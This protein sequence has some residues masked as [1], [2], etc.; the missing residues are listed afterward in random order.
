MPTAPAI[1]AMPA[2]ATSTSGSP[3]LEPTPMAPM[4]PR[5]GTIGNPP[6]RL[7]YLPVVAIASF[8]ATSAC[9]FARRCAPRDSGY[10][11]AYGGIDA[12]E[13]TPVN[14]HERREI[15]TIIDCRDTLRDD[16]CRG[17]R[18]GGFD[19]HQGAVIGE[20]QMLDSSDPCFVPHFTHRN[21]AG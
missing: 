21:S 11:L 20:A 1:A 7:M 16:R 6:L 5:S 13:F 19:D 8:I 3:V 10:R 15:S 9:T 4:T 12:E 2:V 17:F 18:N 14:S